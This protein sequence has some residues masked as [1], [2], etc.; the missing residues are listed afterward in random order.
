VGTVSGVSLAGVFYALERGYFA[1]E[2]IEPELIPFDAAAR[3]TASLAADQLDVGAGGPSAGLFNAIARDVGLRIVGPLARH[4]PG[5]SA[6]Y[7]MV[8]KDLVES[9]QVREYA[10]L[11]GRTVAI[12]AK[13]SVTEYAAHLVAQRGGYALP[14][15]NIVELGFPEMV[16]AF[17]NG[18]IEAAI[19]NDPAATVAHE[20]G[21]AVKW[22]EVADLNPR[23]Q[24][25]VIL[26]SPVF[27]TERA[28]QARRWMVAYLR[29]VRDY[30]AEIIRGKDRPGGIV[31]FSRYTNIPDHALFERVGWTIIDPNGEVDRASLDDQLRWLI[32]QGTVTAGTTLDKAIDP[33]FAASAVARLG[34]Y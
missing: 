11:R 1:E 23:F 13:A 7:I 18:S 26:Y 28:D 29:G 32:A 5:N 3:M 14:D 12:A 16:T 27:A 17:A 6:V 31:M 34:R 19:Q 8:R 4:E 15:L 33:S 2:G 20:R 30:D 24:F 22:R 21:V 10:D 9:G 25:T